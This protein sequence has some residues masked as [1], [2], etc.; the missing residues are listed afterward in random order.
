[1]AISKQTEYVH[2][3]DKENVQNRKHDFHSQSSLAKYA[4]EYEDQPPTYK[5]LL[6][7]MIEMRECQLYKG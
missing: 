6:D 2:H 3:I 7:A 1:M 4:Q 5:S